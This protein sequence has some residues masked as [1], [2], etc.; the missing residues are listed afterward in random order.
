MR[1][2]ILGFDESAAG[3]NCLHRWVPGHSGVLAQV[4]DRERVFKASCDL[5][6]HW[7]LCLRWYQLRVLERASGDQYFARFLRHRV[8][9]LLL[10]FLFLTLSGMVKWKN[11]LVELKLGLRRAL[12]RF[13][14]RFSDVTNSI[15]VGLGRMRNFGWTG[16]R[17]L[18]SVSSDSYDS[19]DRV[20][21]AVVSNLCLRCD[22]LAHSFNLLC[23]REYFHLR[24]CW[25]WE[26]IIVLVCVRVF[27]ALSRWIVLTA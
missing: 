15:L 10:L 27:V 26:G 20:R 9:S 6:R 18:L 17:R 11:R 14:S 3:C 19:L 22:Y 24:D 16:D 2:F 8:L 21:K 7:C 4:I 25:C 13:S 1:V 23:R 12:A 5:L